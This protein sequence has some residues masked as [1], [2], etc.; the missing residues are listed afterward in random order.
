MMLI[1]KEALITEL[2]KHL[3]ALPEPEDWQKFIM[4]AIKG[5]VHNQPEATLPPERVPDPSDGASGYWFDKGW[6]ACLEEMR[7]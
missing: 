6:N 3:H 4:D 7:K 5:I 1:D 2:D